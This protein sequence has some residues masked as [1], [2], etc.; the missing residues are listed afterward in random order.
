MA[1]LMF[2]VL[3]AFAG[4]SIASGL[5]CPV[6]GQYDAN[7]QNHHYPTTF[8][9]KVEQ[10][11]FTA[12]N[13]NIEYA[14][15]ADK[16]SLCDKNVNLCPV[17]EENIRSAMGVAS[18]PQYAEFFKHLG[19]ET[20]VNVFYFG[21]S[22]TFGSE[23]HCRC[24]CKDVEDSRCPPLSIP[25]HLQSQ[26]CSWPSHITRWLNQSYSATTFHFYDHSESGRSSDSALYFVQKVTNAP[27]TANF[28]HPALFFLDY[29]VND[30]SKLT[31]APLETFVR[32]IYD[33][34]SR[35]FNVRPTVIVLEQYA[36]A[37]IHNL[38]FVKTEP[39]YW[40]NYR[41]I[42]KHYNLI[43]ISMQEVYWTYFGPMQ[44]RNF[45]N[46]ELSKRYYPIS[47]FEYHVHMVM[48]PPWYVSLFMADVV[49]EC[50]KRI[51]E[52][53]KGQGR[54]NVNTIGNLHNRALVPAVTYVPP[55]P[56]PKPLFDHSK[57]LPMCS[58]KTPMILNAIPKSVDI[59]TEHL[60]WRKGWIE[61]VSHKTP[62]WEINSQSDVTQRVLSF[63]LSTDIR[64]WENAVVIVTY[65]TSY[66]GM[67]TATVRVCGALLST[68]TLIDG[69]AEPRVSVPASTFYILNGT[70]IERCRA[71]KVEDRMLS[72]V[73]APGKDKTDIR[74]KHDHL[75]K[76][77]SVQ[78]CI[79]VHANNHKN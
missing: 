4:G 9:R 36:F 45:S 39:D 76:V 68:A 48:H 2:C 62:G 34:F 26:Y 5:L 52:Q 6:S 10:K 16:I 75:F 69:L 18:W 42:A 47:P 3:I 35:Q 50:M 25:P 56:L 41:R 74:A 63:P 54:P 32:T 49:A 1:L 70:D 7:Q 67:G 79:P 14:I 17:N 46:P 71:Q 24:R 19:K 28:S 11:S 51:A 60:A 58:I 57:E 8:Y 43:L 55:S 23:T 15:T 53:F 27:K 37:T 73:Y 66:E 12:F 38:P 59:P 72:I 13:C 29:S 77:H 44:G 20:N 22:M 21:G 64:H 65:L 31:T 78:V 30:V 61:H 33:E 40:I